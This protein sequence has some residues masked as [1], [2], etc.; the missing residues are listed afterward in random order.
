MTSVVITG[1]SGWARA[2]RVPPLAPAVRLLRLEAR[3]N[4]MLWM[5]P[6]VVALFWFD[7]YR[8]AT[9]LP[10]F[11][12]QRA[13]YVEM[14]AAL[15]FAPLVAGVAAWA[16]SRDGRRRTT[17]LVDVA[18]RPRWTSRLVT[19]AATTGWAVAAYLCC[20]A[21]VYL[22]TA[23]Q[24]T[25]GGPP[26]WPPAVGASTVVAACALGFAAGVLMPGRLTAPFTAI[27]VFGVFFVALRPI[28]SS[29][30]ALVSPV[31]SSLGLN[32]FPDIAVFYR[33][34]P[35]LAI[36]Q[37][38]LM[39]GLTAASLGVLGLPA[40]AGSR[41][42]H[43]VAAVITVVGLAAAGTAVGLAGTARLD[44]YGM[45][46][47]PALHNAASDRAASYT[48]VCAASPLPVCV[49]PA[50]RA[51]LPDVVASVDPV[52]GQVVGL[53]GAPVRV[54]QVATAFSLNGAGYRTPSGP[55]VS[56]NP[57]VLRLP[58]GPYL[59]AAPAAT[60]DG[61]RLAI[62]QVTIASVIGGSRTPAQQAVGAA[63]LKASGMPLTGAPGSPV[64]AAAR[65]F[66]ALSP[67]ARHAWLAAHL[68]A[69]RAGHISMGE[70]P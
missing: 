25:W 46:T 26:L 13:M 67:A 9:A 33:Y 10:P 20:V 64:Y 3:R 22:A 15:D 60:V 59:T 58:L 57:A 24:A 37:V 17:D 8:V 61:V 35:D 28:G 48:P 44:A 68:S 52:L 36:D 45:M 5:L 62:T 32:L 2:G 66:A 63:L 29:P 6:P 30:Y 39:A 21:A 16:G 56:G 4:A 41:L 49:Q 40:A 53:P 55:S 69:L 19:W 27:V 23:R 65:R 50:F 18:A 47:I 42:L 1:R 12:V 54:T 7:V 11:W 14:H 31:N 34:V 43:R 38:T 51:Y 70:L